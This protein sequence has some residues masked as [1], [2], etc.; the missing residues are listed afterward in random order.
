[1]R[2]HCRDSGRYGSLMSKVN[3]V[4]DDIRVKFHKSREQQDQH[5]ERLHD[6]VERLAEQNKFTPY[7]T[8]PRPNESRLKQCLK[9][10]CCCFNDGS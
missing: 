1:M 7:K 6:E 9:M 3:R 10:L 2:D 8:P 5:Q 4:K